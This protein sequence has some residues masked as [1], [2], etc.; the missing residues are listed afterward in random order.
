MPIPFRAATLGV[1]LA[2]PAIPASAQDVATTP[3]AMTAQLAITVLPAK[4]PQPL[5]VSTPAFASLGDIPFENTR[6]RDNRF[7]GL[8]WSGGPKGAQG[9]AVIMQDPDS[10]VNGMPILHW[11][12]YAI[13]PSVT[14]LE[15][16]MTTAPAGATNGP[17][18]RGLAQP[19]AGPRTPAG[20]KHSYHFQV[21]ALDT[22]IAPD[23]AMTYPNLIAALT[24]HV[25][26][27]GE[28][29]GLGRRDPQAP[30][31]AAPAPPP[32]ASTPAPGR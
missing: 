9:Y 7:P 15:A 5:R 30:P 6:Y 4:S 10:A 21:F 11:T 16:G 24:G 1:I 27:S 2:L 13:A 29:V 3:P 31:P 20:P 19:Y 26:A 22:A 17:N 14:R 25:L 32:P 12:M 8:V 18:I 28:V 23:P